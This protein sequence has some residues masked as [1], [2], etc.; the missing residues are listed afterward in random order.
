MA[1]W[2]DVLRLLPRIALQMLPGVM[3]GGSRV[4]RVLQATAN[5]RAPGTSFTYP[6]LTGPFSYDVQYIPAT[7]TAWTNNNANPGTVELSAPAQSIEEHNAALMNGGPSAEKA[8][9]AW[10]PGEDIKPR[11]PF[12][13]TSSAVSGIRINDNNTISI[14]FRN[15]GKW[16]TYKGGNNP[17]EASEAAKSLLLEES[18]GR[19][20]PRPARYGKTVLKRHDTPISPGVESTRVGFWGT[21]HYEPDSSK[22]RP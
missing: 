5:R 16:Y 18:I 15:K 6:E 20:L 11:V 17:K 9:D 22:W 4:G 3:M 14:Q 2:T 21:N 10:W 8:L 13:A 7:R 12:T 19:A 1:S